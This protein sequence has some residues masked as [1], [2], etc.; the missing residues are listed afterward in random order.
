MHRK[1]PQTITRALYIPCTHC[2]IYFVCMA[3]I[4]NL[5]KIAEMLL[6]CT[7]ISAWFKAHWS[8]FF[9]KFDWFVELTSHID[10]NI[11]RY[12]NFCANNDDDDDDGDTT[13]YFTPLQDNYRAVNNY[14]IREIFRWIKILP[15]PA[16]FVL[17]CNY[18]IYVVLYTSSGENLRQFR[19]P[20]SLAKT[21]I[22]QIF[23]SCVKIA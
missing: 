19:H 15:S 17:Q 3:K 11:S 2:A 4:V 8:Q 23:L 16:T 13:D 12:G 22:T 9:A 21:F 7:M 18:S 6:S 5:R 20:L 14:R 10:T 1:Y